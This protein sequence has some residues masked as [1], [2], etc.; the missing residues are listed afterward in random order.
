MSEALRRIAEAVAEVT[1]EEVAAALVS[2]GALRVRERRAQDLPKTPLPPP[3]EASRI[4]SEVE[5][6]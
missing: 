5:W 1:E 3:G 6:V 2:L 4:R